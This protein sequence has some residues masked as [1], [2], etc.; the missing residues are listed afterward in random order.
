MT[1]YTTEEYLYCDKSWLSALFFATLV[2][3]CS[4]ICSAWLR[5]ITVGPDT[6]DLVSALTRVNDITVPATGSH[7]DGDKRSRLMRDL[8]VRLGDRRPGE[9]VGSVVIGQAF[10]VGELREGRL[11]E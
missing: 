1:V 7:L 10:Q 9:E 4:T 3:L 11:Y 8:R 2:L 6:L 5:M